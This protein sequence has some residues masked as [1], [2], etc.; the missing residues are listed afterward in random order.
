MHA[1]Q[2]LWDCPEATCGNRES[3]LGTGTEL[4]VTLVRLS[5]RRSASAEMLVR[6]GTRKC[7]LSLNVSSCNTIPDWVKPQ[8][9]LILSPRMIQLK[10][11]PQ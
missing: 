7:R 2:E 9:V 3:G 5:W 4:E 6:P 10:Q 1:M 11:L 8:E